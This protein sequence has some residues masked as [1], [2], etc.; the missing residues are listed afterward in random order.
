MKGKINV[1]QLPDLEIYEEDVKRTLTRVPNCKAPG[2]DGVQ[3]SWLKNL[4]SLH[5]RI[6]VYLQRF[7]DGQQT[8]NWMTTGRTTL[9]MKNPVKGNQP[10]TTDLS[11]VYHSRGKH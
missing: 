2:P 3:E 6:G 5:Y 8:S 1:S 7:L 10:G 9:I 4:K 11:H